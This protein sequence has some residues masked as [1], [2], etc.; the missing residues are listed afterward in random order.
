MA[1]KLPELPYAKD[2]LAPY[3]SSETLE[4]H[5]GK[6]HNAY[7]V[8]LNELIPGTK[9]ENATLEQIIMSSDGAIFNQ[10]AQIWNH[11]FYFNCLAPRAG[12][13]PKGKIGA[14]ITKA[15]G[16]FQTFKEKFTEAA[17]SQF[18]SG[19]AWLSLDKSGKLVIEKTSNAQLPMT[20]G[21]RAL[22]TCDVWEHAYYIDYRNL[23]AK[24]V[25]AFW[26]LVNWSEV[27]ATFTK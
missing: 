12:G 23:R 24:Y 13:E 17:I 4:F 20:S 14:E 21:N 2:A 7:V 25:E 3:I 11:T 16:S 19:W 1:F 8:K 15:F 5:H 10:A 26:N 9:H 6:H 22:L 27:E 18:G